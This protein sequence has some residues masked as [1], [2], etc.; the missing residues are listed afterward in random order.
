MAIVFIVR[1]ISVKRT[2]NPIKLQAR[3]AWRVYIMKRFEEIVQEVE[4][5][6]SKLRKYN[7]Q[8]LKG[9]KARKEER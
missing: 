7:L 2:I 6:F 8:N 1:N 3:E 5:E 4:A 9:Y